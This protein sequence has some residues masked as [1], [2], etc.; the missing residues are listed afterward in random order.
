VEIRA[1]TAHTGGLQTV[2]SYGSHA[3]R[4]RRPREG[5]GDGRDAGV[6]T[7]RIA[8]QCYGFTTPS[9]TRVEVDGSA[10]QDMALN[11]HFDNGADTWFAPALVELIDQGA[12]LRSRLARSD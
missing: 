1:G 4:L 5:L 9:L 3:R 12:V 7:R 6:R 10:S 2:G 11:I 8:G